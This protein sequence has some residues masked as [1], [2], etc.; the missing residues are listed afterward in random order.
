MLNDVREYKLINERKHK[1]Q[2]KNR[3][4]I[5]PPKEILKLKNT[6]FKTLLE[7]LNDR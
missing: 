1:F 2:Q 3:N 5:K 7:E 4:Y 6:V